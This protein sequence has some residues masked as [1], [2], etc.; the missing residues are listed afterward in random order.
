MSILEINRLGYRSET[1]DMLTERGMIV[2]ENLYPVGADNEALK[3]A[4]TELY[5]IFSKYKKH[6]D[7]SR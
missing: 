5:D 4:E 6:L 3:K 1:S 7:K 2:I